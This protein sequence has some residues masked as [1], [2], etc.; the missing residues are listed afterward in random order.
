MVKSP[1]RPPLIVTLRFDA[2]TFAWLEI[3]RT[4]H[5]PPR[6]N[7]VP[8]HL[9]LFHQLPGDQADDV[10]ETARR[11]AEDTAPVPLQFTRPI[12]LGNG[13]ALE[14]ESVPL[15]ELRARFAAE[16]FDDLTTQDRQRFR[17]HVTIQNKV[18]LRE[19]R[20]LQ[21]DLERDWRPA[22]GSGEGVLIWRYLAGP[23]TLEDDVAFLRSGPDVAPGWG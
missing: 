15:S 12:S 7:L 1:R 19:A 17:P 21:S 13:V 10:L 5:Y 22:T 4:R 14:V 9:T 18:A 3:L 8:A 11:L 2:E 6:L 20:A 16:W 23:W